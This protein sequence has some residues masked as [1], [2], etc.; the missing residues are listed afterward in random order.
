MLQK[1]RKQKSCDKYCEI[2]NNKNNDNDNNDNLMCLYSFDYKKTY[3]KFQ[4]DKIS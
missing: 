4:D 1:A 2:N 3:E